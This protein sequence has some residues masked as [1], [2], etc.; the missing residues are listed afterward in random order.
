[1]EFDT[2]ASRMNQPRVHLFRGT[3]RSE[4][5]VKLFDDDESLADGVS[6][7]LLEGWQ[8]REPLVVVARPRHWLLTAKR[9]IAGSCP[10]DEAISSGRLTVLDA[11]TTLAGFMRNG[12][13]Q[14]ELF[15]AIVSAPVLRL[16]ASSGKPLRIY[17]E[18]VDVLASQ[19]EFA[20]AQALEN[21]WNQLG[22]R[23]SFKL[24]CGYAAGHFSDPRTAPALRSICEAHD[25]ASA[26]AAD[27]LASWLLAD[28]RPRFH[29]DW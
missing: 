20:A 6:A 14:A 16:A 27:L 25:H 23:V 13:P 18:M 24:L 10:V 26:D 7:F 3:V 15:A 12:R 1:M 8:R 21:L 4:H 2:T 9:L 5:L 11:A 22:T 29:I 17:G 28:R 19:G